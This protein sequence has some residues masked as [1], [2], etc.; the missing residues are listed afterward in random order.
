VTLWL[1]LVGMGQAKCV[2]DVR[3]HRSLAVYLA[4][5]GCAWR[6][7]HVLRTGV[8]PPPVLGASVRATS[9]YPRRFTGQTTRH[10]VESDKGPEIRWHT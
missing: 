2:L 10:L 6:S 5:P 7:P 3:G 9:S 1:K 4:E 8:I